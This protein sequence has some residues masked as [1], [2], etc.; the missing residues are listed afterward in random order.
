[1]QNSICALMFFFPPLIIHYLWHLRD[2]WCHHNHQGLLSCKLQTARAACRV[3]FNNS[4]VYYLFTSLGDHV[5]GIFIECG[6]GE[7]WSKT[8]HKQPTHTRLQEQWRNLR[9]LFFQQA[10]NKG[11]PQGRGCL[12]NAVNT[13]FSQVCSRLQNTLWKRSEIRPHKCFSGEE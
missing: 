3:T 9:V 1:M 2:V 13:H 8:C 12:P 10:C 4:N 5:Y 11:L 6:I 7:I